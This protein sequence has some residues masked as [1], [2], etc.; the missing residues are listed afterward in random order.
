[1]DVPITTSKAKI[2]QQNTFTIQF[3]QEVPIF[4]SKEKKPQTHLSTSYT[5]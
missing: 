1:M 4:V 2:V 5:T 3:V